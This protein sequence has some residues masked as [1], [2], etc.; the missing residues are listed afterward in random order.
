MPVF[1]SSFCKL[2]RTDQSNA[3]SVQSRQFTQ[4]E[5]SANVLRPVNVGLE[6]IM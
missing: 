4:T 1:E 5:E 6:K 3:A 2:S